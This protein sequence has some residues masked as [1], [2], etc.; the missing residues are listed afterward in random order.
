MRRRRP[1]RFSGGKLTYGDWYIRDWMQSS[2][3]ALLSDTGYRLYHLVCLRVMEMGL[4]PADRR[5]IEA[6]C[7]GVR[8][9]SAA[10]WAEVVP[11]LDVA[12]DGRWF[13]VRALQEHV[14][15][16]EACLA[17]AGDGATAK[18]TAHLAEC[19]D[20]L[21][22]A[23]ASGGKCGGK[24]CIT[25][26]PGEKGEP[27]ARS[28]FSSPTPREEPE[29][30]ASPPA[31]PS[32]AAQGPA[33]TTGPE[34]GTA[35]APGRVRPPMTPEEASRELQGFG[36]PPGPR[37][38]PIPPPASPGEPRCHTEGCE[39]L[40]VNRSEIHGGGCKVHSSTMGSRVDWLQCTACGEE[41]AHVTKTRT[42][43]CPLCAMEAPA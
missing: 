33:G 1:R 22:V 29:S 26:D 28:P 8:G 5:A 20:A 24:V 19:E 17:K 43:P 41:W 2:E 21:A 10:A 14:T 31:A 38:P 30:L 39:G 37:E 6:L 9:D 13:Q 18:A 3:V 32:L 27:T 34:V 4:L 23:H 7:P 40:V 12:G 15:G 42:R 35:T 11:L 16:L 25:Q 36:T